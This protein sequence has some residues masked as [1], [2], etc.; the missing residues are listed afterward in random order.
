M[1]A[2]KITSRQAQAART[3]KKIYNVAVELMNKQG[4]EKTTIS[5]ISKKA[6]V[7]VGA[8]YLY[9]KSKDDIFYEKYKAF[10]AYFEKKVTPLL[11]KENAKFDKIIAFFEAYAIWDKKQGYDAIRKLYNT[12]NKLFTDKERYP[13]KLLRD[14]IREA[15]EKNQIIASMSTE[16]IAEFLFTVARG[17]IYDWCLNFA[18]Y[19]LEERMVFNFELLGIIFKTEKTQPY[20]SIKND[21]T[22]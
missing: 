20:V 17:T 2:K 15:Q 5:Q 11:I 21:I 6:G 12:Q 1:I 16:D 14:L 18:A 19:D 13:H 22:I 9:F 10:D 3:K 8:F 7:S 4:F